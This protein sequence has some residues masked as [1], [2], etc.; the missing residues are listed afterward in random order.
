MEKDELKELIKE[1]ILE[2][3]YWV[4]R[5][6]IVRLMNEIERL[7]DGTYEDAVMGWAEK[8]SDNVLKKYVKSFSEV[9]TALKDMQKYT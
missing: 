1:C 5:D 7:L 3:A 4:S 9:K 8:T 6:S 2:E